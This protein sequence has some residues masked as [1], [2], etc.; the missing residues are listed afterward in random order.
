[1][2]KRWR[3]FYILHF[4]F[5]ILHLISISQKLQQLPPGSF[6]R[7]K[8]LLERNGEWHRGIEACCPQHG[9]IE[10]LEQ[11]FRD[12]GGN[13]TANSPKQGVF[14]EDQ[15]LAGSFDGCFDGFVI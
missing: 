5:Y 6:Y 12:P 8:V 10:V 9:R 3:P 4:A 13:F 2:T 11:V 7:E 14:M 1:M 15:H